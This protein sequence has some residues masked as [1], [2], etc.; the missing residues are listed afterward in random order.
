MVAMRG[1]GNVLGMHVH[2][3]KG[4]SNANILSSFGIDSRFPD[5]MNPILMFLSPSNLLENHHE[6]FD[7]TNRRLGKDALAFIDEWLRWFIYGTLDKNGILPM[8]LEA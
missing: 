7:L 4:Y 2:L 6:T 3:W 1:L 5:L 8:V